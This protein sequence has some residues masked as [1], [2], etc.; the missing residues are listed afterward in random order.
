MRGGFI[1]HVREEDN[2]TYIG[3]DPVSPLTAL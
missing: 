1:S 3:M 2:L